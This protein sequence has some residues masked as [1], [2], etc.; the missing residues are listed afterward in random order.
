M[1]ENSPYRPP[2]SDPA[3]NTIGEPAST[4]FG[5]PT[6]PATILLLVS[7]LAVCWDAA[8]AFFLIFGDGLAIWRGEAANDQIVP[9]LTGTI[10]QIVLLGTHIVILSTTC[11]IIARKNYFGSIRVCRFAF[12]PF[13]SPLIIAGIPFAIW[14]YKLL[15]NDAV[16]Q[17]FEVMRHSRGKSAEPHTRDQLELADGD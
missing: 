3:G 16:K 7:L 6:I 15:E 8:L 9:F 1:K 14:I 10:W 2:Q 13:L 17:E 4:G 11:D 12:V 5:N